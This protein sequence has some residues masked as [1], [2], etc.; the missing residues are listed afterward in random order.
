[1]NVAD[2]PT[3]SARTAP[4]QYSILPPAISIPLRPL[5]SQSCGFLRSGRSTL[6]QTLLVSADVLPVGRAQL[7]EDGGGEDRQ[8]AEGDERLV[9]AVDHLLWIGVVS[10]RDEEGRGQRRRG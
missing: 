5:G 9:H 1:M 7:A 2:R 10:I 4:I 8:E 3:A 6:R